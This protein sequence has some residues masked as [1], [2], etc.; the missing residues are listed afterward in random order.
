MYPKLRPVEA[1]WISHQGRPALFLH[2]R[3][4]LCDQGVVVPAVLAPLISLVDG[5]RDIPMLQTACELR[6]GVRVPATL[7]EQ[8]V[9]QLDEALLLD[10]PRFKAAWQRAL[11]EYRSAPFRQPALAGEGY[12][13]D[14]KALE[15]DLQG[16]LDQAA[17]LGND[18][19][20]AASA[21]GVVVPHIDFAR[22]GVVY[23]QVWQT[24]GVALQEAD[25][26]VVLGTDH[27][28]TR[29]GLTLTRQ[30]YAT[31]WGVLPTARSVVDAIAEAIGPDNAFADEL[32]HR[33]EH[34]IELAATW[35]HFLRRRTD[36]YL[37]P[38]LCGSFQSFI[39]QS[40]NPTDHPILHQ[41]LQALAS[42]TVGTRVFV[43]AAGDLAHVG[44][45]FGDPLPYG[46]AERAM[47]S[48]AD[49]RLVDAICSGD[50]QA[51]LRP[52]A[53]ERDR[54]RVCGLPPIYLA[55]SILGNARGRPIAYCQCPA[56]TNGGSLVSIAGVILS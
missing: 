38:I 11:D 24:A 34:S 7:I 2:D 51:F 32:H 15:A 14:A 27:S 19:A 18:T 40:T 56:D 37:V 31:P 12:P 3:L 50:A 5:T 45:A 46:P 36:Y 16:Y 17:T 26:V 22:G 35:V 41:A 47:L 1:K 4:G 42:A 29:P 43:I 55:L 10:S 30:Q 13:A 8:L 49:S 6:T 52:I 39:D 54:R 25:I 28:S 9:A 33:R 48:A 20:A 23:A 53:D 21:R 44:P